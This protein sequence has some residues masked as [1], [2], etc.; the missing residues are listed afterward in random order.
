MILRNLTIIDF[1]CFDRLHLVSMDGLAVFIGENDA[2]K[3]SILDAIDLLLSSRSLSRDDYRK[4]PDGSAVDRCSLRGV[5][6]LE[7]HDTVPVEY[8]S[9]PAGEFLNLTKSFFPDRVEVMVLGQGY[10]D[11]R[12]DTFR[13]AEAQKSLLREYGLNPAGNEQGR[14]EQVAALLAA[15]KLE[16]VERPL[17]VSFGTLA[18]HLPR[19]QRIAA[20]DYRAP[21]SMVQRALQNV[22]SGVIYSEDDGDREPKEL[23]ALTDIRAR[24]RVRLDEEIEKAQGALQKAHP[25]I[26]SVSVEPAIDFTRCVTA[27]NLL[28]DA[29]EGERL[30]SSFGEGTKKRIWM[31]LLEWE[32]STTSGMGQSLIRLYDE[33]DV[34]LH[35]EA[36][37]RLFETICGLAGEP[38][39]RTQCFV[40][41]HSLTL[42]D[43]SPVES[44]HLLRLDDGHRRSHIQINQPGDLDII[45][46]FNEV[47]RAVGLSNSALL[48]ERAFLVVEGES[49]EAAMPILYRCLF[50]RSLVEDG[51]VLINLHTC[52]AWKAV[53]EVL[54]ANRLPLTQLLLDQDC[55]DPNSSGHITPEALNDLGCPADFQRDQVSYVGVKEFEDAF[56]DGVICR[57]LS[58]EFARVDG[59]SWDGGDLANLRSNSAKFS[60]DLK[61]LVRH[62]CTLARRNDAT[63]PAIAAA[64][65]RACRTVADVPP[66][67]TNALI[68]LRARAGHPSVE[69]P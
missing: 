67:I 5:F 60:S 51:I 1:R 11:D 69:L 62:S 24:I 36:Q 7:P 33:P 38:I 45:A 3:T 9:G 28:V 47:G 63:K 64:V 41:T 66:A 29:G 15:G 37:R 16:L 30:V 22:V 39:P 35:Y 43:R 21:D 34:N 8:R 68:A 12:F 20:T 17:T 58:A 48:Y 14:R 2:G 50:G 44:I 31:G 6:Q 4:L 52:S 32:R 57:A 55:T 19:V 13:P 42:I 54:L 56:S 65:A 25:G 59:R 27:T 10:S 61:Q 53:L 18:P 49:E 26:R 40:C 46:F 23:A